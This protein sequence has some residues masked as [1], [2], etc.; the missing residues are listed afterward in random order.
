[1]GGF[2]SLLTRVWKVNNPPVSPKSP[3]ALRFGILGKPWTW[4]VAFIT[5]AKSHSDVIVAA[6]AS[7]DLARAKAPLGRS[8]IRRNL[9][10]PPKRLALRV[11]ASSS[12]SRKSR[13]YRKPIVSNAPEAASLFNYHAS[14]PEASRPVLVEA[15]HPRFH[16]AWHKFISLIDPKNIE[17]FKSNFSVSAGFF[18]KGNIRWDFDLAG[19]S[20]MDI[21]TYSVA[22]LRDVFRAEPVECTSA[23]ARLLPKPGDQRVDTCFDAKFKFPNGGVGRVEADLARKGW[24]G[25]PSIKMAKIVVKE[26]D[27]QIDDEARVFGPPRHIMSRTVTFWGFPAAHFWHMIQVRERHVMID[28]KTDKVVEKWEGKRNMTAYVWT[29]GEMKGYLHWST[30]RYML[31]EFVCK[32][33]RRKGTGLGLMARTQLNRPR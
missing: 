2:I 12:Q 3:D 33:R 32:I 9:S 4:S 7:R 22:A 23:Q 8:D 31:D 30:Y 17:R 10:R 6:V 11:D 16:P 1:M 25:L 21:G 24:F 26:K 13:P 27:V 29:E 20:L 14:L 28:T 19:G 15:F 18:P 5:P